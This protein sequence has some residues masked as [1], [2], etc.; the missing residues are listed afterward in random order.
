MDSRV[1]RRDVKI[2]NLSTNISDWEVFQTCVHDTSEENINSKWNNAIM[3]CEILTTRAVKIEFMMHWDK[4]HSS[5]TKKSSEQEKKSKLSMN[6]NIF[7]D[8]FMVTSIFFFNINS[9]LCDERFNSKRYCGGKL[10]L[11]RV[12]HGSAW[13]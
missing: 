10:N 1:T 8:V 9:Q 3:K 2:I 4:N 7:S 5:I 6:L 11:S 12:S 13:Y